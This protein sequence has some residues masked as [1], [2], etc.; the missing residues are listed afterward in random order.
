MKNKL[1]PALDHLTKSLTLC[2]A[3]IDIQEQQS[4]LYECTIWGGYTELVTVSDNAP[5]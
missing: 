1:Q 4:Q 5:P 3:L 2:T